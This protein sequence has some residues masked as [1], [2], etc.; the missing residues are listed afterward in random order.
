MGSDLAGAVH[1]V[2]GTLGAG[3]A[4]CMKVAGAAMATVL[5]ASIAQQQSRPC[6]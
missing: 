2:S 5:T 4:G 6:C 3:R 1:Q